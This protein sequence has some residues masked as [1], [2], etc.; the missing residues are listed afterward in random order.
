MG[1]CQDQF[2][3]WHSMK[4]V[5]Q[6]ALTLN[7]TNRTALLIVASAVIWNIWHQRNQLCFKHIIVHSC[8]TVIFLLC[9]LWLIGQV[10]WRRRFRLLWMNGCPQIWWSSLAGGAPRGYTDDSMD[11]QWF[12]LRESICT[13]LYI[14]N[15]VLVFTIPVMSYVSRQLRACMHWTACCVLR[16]AC[17]LNSFATFLL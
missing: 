11:F 2:Y 6:F 7:K 17:L 4:D 16:Y 15:C 3:Q 5:I 14:L 8:R 13:T 12:W 10:R 9:L 1:K